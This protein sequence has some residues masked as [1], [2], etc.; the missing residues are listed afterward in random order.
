MLLGKAGR[1]GVADPSPDNNNPLLHKQMALDPI[2]S[3]NLSDIAR[4]LEHTFN[5][6]DLALC[7]TP[8]YRIAHALECIAKS[9]D[10]S[11]VPSD[12]TL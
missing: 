5:P 2:D 12:E 4:A 3:E 7:T 10:S 8:L 6:E 11:F 1:L 9:M